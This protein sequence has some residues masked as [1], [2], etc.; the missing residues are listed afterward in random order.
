M[1]TLMM[2]ASSILQC[3]LANRSLTVCPEM[4]DACAVGWNKTND[5]LYTH[6][7]IKLFQNGNFWKYA[8]LLLIHRTQSVRLF[9]YLQY[10]MLLLLYINYIV[11]D[12]VGRCEENTDIILLQILIHTGGIIVYHISRLWRPLLYS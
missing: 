1:L 9:Y 8:L 4:P 10:N 3:G 5:N 2:K 11:T 12:S 6:L 7:R